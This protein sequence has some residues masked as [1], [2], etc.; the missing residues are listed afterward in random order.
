M[1]PN[2]SFSKFAQHILRDSLKVSYIEHLLSSS[3]SSKN[4]EVLTNIRWGK[5]GRETKS[6]LIHKTQM[7]VVNSVA[8]EQSTCHNIYL[9]WEHIAYES[10]HTIMSS[11]LIKSMLPSQVVLTLFK[12]SHS[13]SAISIHTHLS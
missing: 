2:P 9:H 12:G 10:H 11:I 6:C 8:L 4:K 13:E 5:K 1:G 7:A 3:I